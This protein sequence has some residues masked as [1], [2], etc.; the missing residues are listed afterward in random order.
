[1]NNPLSNWK[2][3]AATHK[4]WVMLAALVIGALLVGVHFSDRALFNALRAVIGVLHDAVD[5]VPLQVILIYFALYVATA[6]VSLPVAGLLT[7]V[8]GALFGFW[9][10]MLL[11]SVSASTGALAGFL[12]SRY[13]FHGAVQRRFGARL[14]PIH[15]GLHEEGAFYLFA[16]RMVPVFPFWLVNLLMGLT[17]MRA[18]T[19]WWVSALGL[20]PL[21]AAYVFAG[22]QLATITKPSDILSPGLIAVL[23]GLAL[24]PLLLR[25]V[26]RWAER[27]YFKHEE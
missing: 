7:L 2:Q 10:G 12:V 6:A 27:R 14:A 3:V 26:V 25:R 17:S 23:L 13:L 1:M 22:T 8:A 5:D 19:F 9:W 24:L 20:L 21:E 18:F 15:A 4:W 11:A 16:L